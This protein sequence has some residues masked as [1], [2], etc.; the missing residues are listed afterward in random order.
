MTATIGIPWVLA[1]YYLVSQPHTITGEADL[2]ADFHAKAAVAASVLLLSTIFLR[3]S[4]RGVAATVPFAVMWMSALTFSI[5]QVREYSGEYVCEDEL[6][7]PDF[8]LY[9][10]AVP[11]AVAVSVAVVSSAVTNRFLRDHGEAVPDE[12]R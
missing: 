4:G 1:V 10:T 12:Y 3:L 6:C 7:I 2:V 8:G 5:F 9:L 11:F